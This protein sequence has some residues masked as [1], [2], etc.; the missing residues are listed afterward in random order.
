MITLNSIG[1][2]TEQIRK[3]IYENKLDWREYRAKQD[4]K[5]KKA[6]MINKELL[7]KYKLNKQK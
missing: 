1:F 6:Y 5:L 2:K 3:C 4:K 7:L